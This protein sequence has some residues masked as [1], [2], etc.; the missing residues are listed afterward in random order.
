MQTNS[1]NFETFFLLLFGLMRRLRARKRVT[2]YIINS[3]SLMPESP[4]ARNE[5]KRTYHH[6]WGNSEFSECINEQISLSL[7]FNNDRVRGGVYSPIRSL[8]YSRWKCHDARKMPTRNGS[9]AAF[10]SFQRSSKRATSFATLPSG[11]RDV[12]IIASVNLLPLSKPMRVNTPPD[13]S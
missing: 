3:K 13:L 11:T 4:C 2:Q 6:C 10:V 1:A 7:T 8:C 12:L 9:V 5:E